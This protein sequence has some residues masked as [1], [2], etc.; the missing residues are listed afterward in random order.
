[1]LSSSG[2]TV[3]RKEPVLTEVGMWSYK[4]AQYESRISK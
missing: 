2:V 1:L 3:A 4:Q